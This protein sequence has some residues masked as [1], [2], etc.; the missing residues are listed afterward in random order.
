M[1]PKLPKVAVGLSRSWPVVWAMLFL[2][3]TGWGDG[4]NTGVQEG[5]EDL[6]PMAELL[7]MSKDDLARLRQSL[8]TVE[9][10][11]PED[12]RKALSRI[13]NQDKMPTEQRKETID[14]WNELNPEMKK[15]YFDHVRRLSSTERKKFKAQPWDKQ[16]SEVKENKVKL[17]K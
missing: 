5:E 14:R 11:S 13:Q 7:K 15:A 12:R 10:M 1:N 9:K 3:L 6:V 8:E 16:I 17:S 2:G 4:A